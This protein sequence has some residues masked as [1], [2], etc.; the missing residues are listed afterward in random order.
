MTND[1]ERCTYVRIFSSDNPQ[2]LQLVARGHGA[3]ADTIGPEA[4]EDMHLSQGCK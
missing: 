1:D 4:H 3:L 2:T